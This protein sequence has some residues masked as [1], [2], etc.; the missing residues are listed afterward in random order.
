M[1]EA[2]VGRGRT[3]DAPVEGGR[4]ESTGGGRPHCPDRVGCSVGV[5]AHRNSTSICK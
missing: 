3:W 1:L 2:S 5:R 4:A